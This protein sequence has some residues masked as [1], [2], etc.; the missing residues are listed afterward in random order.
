ME[1]VIIF[2]TG[3][4]A[5]ETYEIMSGLESYEVI[6][7]ADNDCSKCGMKKN[8]LSVLSAESLRRFSDAVIVIASSYYAEISIQLQE[9]GINLKYYESSFQLMNHYFVMKFIM[10]N[11][12]PPR[13]QRFNESR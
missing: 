11:K 1:K 9:M 8:D 10:E 2:G 13:Y 3:Q 6:A 7:F 12:K 5:D 4:M